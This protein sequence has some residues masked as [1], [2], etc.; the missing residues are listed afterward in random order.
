MIVITHVLAGLALTV[1]PV[2]L[3]PE[4]APVAAALLG[5]GTA[6]TAV[7]KRFPPY[8]ERFVD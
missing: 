7:H 4:F 2:V 8:F 6:Y 1:P 5:V 3:A